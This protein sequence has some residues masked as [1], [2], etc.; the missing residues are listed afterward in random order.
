MKNAVDTLTEIQSQIDD[1]RTE[2]VEAGER[3]HAG[4]R[5]AWENLVRAAS[6]LE[7]AQTAFRSIAREKSDEA[8]EAIVFDDTDD[9]PADACDHRDDRICE[10]LGH[11]RQQFPS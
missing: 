8:P 11:G 1:L 7:A 5:I 4:G 10:G 2:A 3:G 6:L 9:E